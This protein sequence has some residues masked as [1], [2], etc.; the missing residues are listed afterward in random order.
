MIFETLS[1]GPLEV[2]C[3]VL[4]ADEGGQAV[5]IDPGADED[6]IRKALSRHGLKPGIIINTHGH[7]D[8]IGA[9]D[10]FGVPVYIHTREL[11]FLKDPALNMSGLLSG[12]LTVKARVNNIEEG[13][14]VELGGIQLQVIHMP[15]HTPGGIALYLL[16]PKDKILFTG[17]SLFNMSVGRTDFPGSDETALLQGI[18]NK[19][20][21]YPDDTVIYPG[22]GASST[23]GQEKRRNP[24][25]I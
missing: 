4:A 23:I 18:K 3:Y 8:H 25:L 24:F 9:D 21:K 5:I 13:D 20:L 1:V 16:K 6:K 11:P 17:D 12:D 10:A 15:G 19:L 7:A 14:M 22:H 2:N